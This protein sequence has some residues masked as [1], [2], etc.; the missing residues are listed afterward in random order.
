MLFRSLD[1][2]EL[3]WRHGH[4][5]HQTRAEAG[6]GGLVGQGQPGGAHQL[7]DLFL[8][9]PG[10]VE[11]RDDVVL[12]RGAVTRT[13]IPAVGGVVAVGDGAVAEARGEVV[14]EAEK[15]GLAVVAAV[16]A[17]GAVAG[18]RQLVAPNTGIVE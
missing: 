10:L 11:R 7:P 14:A 8:G 16:R 5:R 13:E 9:E 17:V 12:L 15:L 1:V 2:A 4:A 3:R 18:A 6:A